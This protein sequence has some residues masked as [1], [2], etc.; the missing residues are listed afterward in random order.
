MKAVERN[1]SFGYGRQKALTQQAD[2]VVVE[3]DITEEV[4]E[5]LHH[6][7]ASLEELVDALRTLA[8]CHHLT[9][10]GI[11]AEQ[12]SSHCL[13]HC[14]RHYQLVVLKARLDMVEYSGNL[15]E[16]AL[17]EL[18][19]CNVIEGESEFLVCVVFTVRLLCRVGHSLMS[20][21]LLHQLHCRIV[22]AA[23]CHALLVDGN[24]LQLMHPVIPLNSVMSFLRHT[25]QGHKRKHHQ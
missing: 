15:R 20:D 22:L 7:V 12:A 16:C 3:I 10:V 14:H 9:A 5:C 13:R 2:I 25:H 23:I 24:A 19:G 18:F 1:R 4:P 17:G 21:N 11:S 8:Y 6:L